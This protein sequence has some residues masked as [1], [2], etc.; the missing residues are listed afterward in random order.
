MVKRWMNYKM[1]SQTQTDQSNMVKKLEK[2]IIV[3]PPQDVKGF[4]LAH[5]LLVIVL[6]EIQT[7]Q[8]P[9]DREHRV[10]MY[11]VDQGTDINQEGLVSLMKNSRDHWITRESPTRDIM[12]NGKS[13]MPP[14]IL[15]IQLEES[16]VVGIMPGN[17]TINYRKMGFVQKKEIIQRE[18]MD[19]S[20]MVTI[21]ITINLLDQ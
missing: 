13:Q 19:T 17:P 7:F 15:V 16:E 5:C 12:G 3:H 1:I 4:D 6:T 14:A 10:N 21:I 20:V 9:H 2:R 8:A 18:K 11:P